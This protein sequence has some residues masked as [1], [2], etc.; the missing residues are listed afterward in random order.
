LRTSDALRNAV[1]GPHAVLDARV[2]T[3]LASAGGCRAF[4]LASRTVVVPWEHELRRFDWPTDLRIDER[5]RKGDWLEQDFGPCNGFGSGIG[6][7]LAHADN[8]AE[9]W[10]ALY[11]FEGSTLG[12]T[13]IARIADGN[14]FRYLRGYGEETHTMWERLRLSL[15]QA[16]SGGAELE[17]CVTAA[18]RVFAQFEE[19]L[20]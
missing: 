4:L 17:S 12:A 13:V 14:D 7:T 1:A 15:D 3:L 8:Q 11:V 20:D 2:R 5:L 10:G 16:V 18:R 6:T 9:A 19:A